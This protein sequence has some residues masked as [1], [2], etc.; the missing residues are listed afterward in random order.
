VNFTNFV[1]TGCSCLCD[2]IE[3]NVEGEQI[4][5]LVNAC[6]RGAAFLQESNEL[7][8]RSYC[9][10]AGHE[11]NIEQAIEAAAQLLHNSAK[12]LIFGLDNS[13]L[14]A[15]AV[16]IELA[17]ALGAVIDDCSSFCQGALI[18]NILNGTLP[19]CSLPEVKDTD[20]IVYWGSNPYHSQPRHLSKF[21]YYT[22]EKFKP[23]WVPDMVLSSIDVRDTELFLLCNPSFKLLPG[24][25]NNF[26]NDAL[27]SIKGE[28]K[29]KDAK[30][31]V[32]LVTKSHFCVIFVGLGLTYA[33]DGNF[34]SF[35]ELVRELSRWTRIAVIPMVGHFNMR[36]FNHSLYHRVCYVN[37]VSFADGI[38]HGKQF[39]F[40][41]QVINHAADCI[42]IVG[43]DPLSNLP[44]SVTKELKGM[45][46]ITIDPFITPT[47][48][49]SQVV[50]SPAISGL[51]SSGKAIRM[52]GIEVALVQGKKTER[53]SDEEILKQLLERVKR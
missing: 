45:P 25:D 18:D 39:S 30:A 36:G 8:R 31:F 2:D 24:E 42:L 5:Q 17:Q 50:L 12:R 21:S 19:T 29:R 32:E 13:T 14:E 1:C 26:I 49:A 51:E 6:A 10:V 22:H 33:L 43:S 38:C 34:Q 48:K 15:Q 37:K 35:A 11:V 52:D 4:T 7:K 23:G 41:E 27:L 46:V 40:V 20:L 16:G 53:L 3:L 44:R 47:T 9:S 28:G